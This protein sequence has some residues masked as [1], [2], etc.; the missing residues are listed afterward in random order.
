MPGWGGMSLKGVTQGSPGMALLR[1]ALVKGGL[2]GTASWGEALRHL[3]LGD[4][5][6]LGTHKAWG[7][8]G[9]EQGR[10]TWHP[11]PPSAMVC[12]LAG[13]WGTCAC[14]PQ[15]L[16]SVWPNT[17]EQLDPPESQAQSAWCGPGTVLLAFVSPALGRPIP[18]RTAWLA[19]RSLTGQWQGLRDTPSTYTSKC[20]KPAA[21]VGR[22]KPA[23]RCVSHGV[24]PIVH[25]P[26]HC[27]TKPKQPAQQVPAHG[28]ARVS[29]SGQDH[30]QSGGESTDLQSVAM[31]ELHK[32]A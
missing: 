29:W 2:Q 9:R 5:G 23:Q 24:R 30:T 11:S 15:P 20:S 26:R 6:G 31:A 21:G 14:I 10:A 32:A 22:K 19:D 28:T 1:E 17:A 4:T 18:E 16:R 13:Q 25:V 7:H 8:A 27:V 3:R 12:E